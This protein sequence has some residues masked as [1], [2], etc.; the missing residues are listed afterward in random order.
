MSAYQSILTVLGWS[1]LDSIWQMAVMW[2]A[3]NMITAGNKLISPA[4]KHNLILLFVFVGTEWFV[5]TFI[6]LTL[7]PETAFLPGLIPVSSSTNRWIL[8]LCLIYLTILLIR[9]LQ[10]GFHFYGAWGKNENLV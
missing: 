3:Y 8:Y 7:E 1:L 9:L 10:Q 4:G 2:I 6:R 5:Y